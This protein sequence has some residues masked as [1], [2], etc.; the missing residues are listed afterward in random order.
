MTA[1]TRFTV[2]GLTAIALLLTA[3]AGLLLLG[4]HL[5]GDA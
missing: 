2:Q 3:S 5:R 4:H 1:G